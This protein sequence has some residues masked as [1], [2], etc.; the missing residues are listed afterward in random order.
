MPTVRLGHYVLGVHGLALLRGWL[1]GAP[2]AADQVVEL[3]RLAAEMESHPLLGFPLEIP[4]VDVSAGYAAWAETYDRL[5]NPLVRVE[6]PV[7]RAMIDELPRGVVLDAACGT[8]RHAEY[9]SSR[10]HTVIGIDSSREMLRRA[11]ERVPSG[12]FAR[13]ELVDLPLASGSIDAAVCALALTHCRSIERPI[14]ELARVLRPGG[15]LMIS[16]FH[17][18][19]LVLGGEALFQAA[20]GSYAFVHSH[21]HSHGE[22]FDA[23]RAAGLEI[24]KCIEPRW[25]ED[26]VALIAGPLLAAAPHAFRQ[27][28]I[29][30]PAALIWQLSRRRTDRHTG[31]STGS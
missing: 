3:A 5:P 27:A 16:D 24:E 12:S 29:G 19:A 6:E 10:G 2:G 13:G 9:L 31:S 30:L 18:M 15:R 17:P 14:A 28:M 1:T 20:D 22:Y 4:G 11:R 21:P 26:E 23:F 7:V 8:G 25:S